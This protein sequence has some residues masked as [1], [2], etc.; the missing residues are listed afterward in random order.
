MQ[1]AS[2]AFLIAL[3]VGATFWVYAIAATLIREF[4]KDVTFVDL[5]ALFVLGVIAGIG[6]GLIVA[7]RRR[8]NGT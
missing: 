6:R 1:R 3:I 7:L 8:N 2:T 4:G 5:G